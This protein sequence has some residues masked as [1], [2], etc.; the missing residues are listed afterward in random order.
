MFP[1]LGAWAG[2]AIGLMLGALVPP[3]RIN[4]TLQA[5]TGAFPG[6]PA[7]RRC[8]A[9]VVGEHT[10]HG[11]RRPASGSPLLDYRGEQAARHL[12]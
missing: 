6:M 5:R 9:V 11:L 1:L 10:G 2:G 3:Q 8:A 4:V 12:G 7:H